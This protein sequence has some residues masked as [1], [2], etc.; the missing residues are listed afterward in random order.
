MPN[1]KNL[2]KAKAKKYNPHRD[3]L[4]RFTTAD[5]ARL[6]KI[7]NHQ[8]ESSRTLTAQQKLDGLK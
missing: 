2:F 1:L 5:K 6:L 3:R 8:Q 4:G 7:T